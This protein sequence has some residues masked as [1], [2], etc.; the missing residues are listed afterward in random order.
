MD[1]STNASPPS[2]IVEFGRWLLS[3]TG[4]RAI[5]AWFY[6]LLGGFVEGVSVLLLIPLLQLA[7][8]EYQTIG[9]AVPI[10][11]L[12]H[13]IAHQVR[14]GLG[15]VLILFVVLMA[16]QSM[17]VR[18]KNIY[19][20]EV[21][22]HFMNNIQ[23]DVFR[24]IGLAKWS[25][26]AM[27][28]SSDLNHTMTS[29]IE[30]L[31]GAS[32]NFMLIVQTVVLLIIYLAV[33]ALI[34]VPMT[35]FAVSIGAVAFLIVRPIRKRAAKHGQLLTKRGQAKYG[36]VSEFLTG[37]KIA[38]I[39]DAEQRYITAFSE[40]LEMQANEVNS[41]SKIN[42]I[43]TVVFQMAN[44]IGL[45]AFVYLA[46]A[47]FKLNLAHIIAMVF[48]FMRIAPRF[49]SLQAQF[50]EMLIGLPAWKSVTALQASCENF[51]EPDLTPAVPIPGLHRSI[52]FKNVTFAYGERLVISNANLTIQAGEITA[53][54][55]ASGSGK[56]TLADLL[57]GLLEP[58]GGAIEIDGVPLV[59]DN[60]K[61][62]RQRVAYVP[63]DVFLL[64]D[65]IAANLAIAKLLATEEEM[66]VALEQANA[67]TFISALPDQLNT[68]VGDRGARLSGGERQRIALAR[69]LLRQ[70]DLLILDEATSALDGEN[71]AMISSALQ[72]LRHHT[73]ILTIAHRHAMVAIADKVVVLEAGRVVE[74][75]S[76][77]QIANSPSGRLASL[78]S[79]D[80]P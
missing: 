60:M 71:Q 34:S 13:L 51:V 10:P 47:V 18:F 5:L 3:R 61:S 45:A 78:I 41:W 19:M 28:R 23:V 11:G 74:A 21:V 17:F 8:P 27:M 69:A 40:N 70:P 59:S 49:N 46:L 66:W 42:S 54:T 76:L 35:L 56:S 58:Q 48:V 7:G 55:G 32:F 26:V 4:P 16:A 14:L 1:Q 73:T 36:I 12:P 72:R 50:Q 43:S 30:R 63:Q 44:V 33:A 38:K 80:G 52:T 22:M 37:L 57:M 29:D 75:G 79:H 9:A 20:A 6:L 67:K 31:N 25:R 39:F 68:M 62:W 77:E 65:T 24:S 64:H 15:P 53:L 2:T